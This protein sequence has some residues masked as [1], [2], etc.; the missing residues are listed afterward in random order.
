MVLFK[1]IILNRKINVF[2]NTARILDFFQPDLYRLNDIILKLKE[3]DIID[4]L[5]SLN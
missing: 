3:S 2:C 5:D 1:N 4:V